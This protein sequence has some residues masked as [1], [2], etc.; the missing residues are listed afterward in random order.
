MIPTTVTTGTNISVQP[1]CED[2]F[3]GLPRG[4]LFDKVTGK[5]PD[6]SWRVLYFGYS[7]Q[8]ML[9]NWNNTLSDSTTVEVETS[10]IGQTSTHAQ[11][12]SFQ[13]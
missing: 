2:G 3:D 8:K 6:I 12:F 11:Y 1:H 9:S 10:Q 13:D 5:I 7:R 4:I